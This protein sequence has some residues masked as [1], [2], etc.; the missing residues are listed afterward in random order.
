MVGRNVSTPERHPERLGQIQAFMELALQKDAPLAE[1]AALA[2]KTPSMIAGNSRLTPVEQLDIYREQFWLRHVGALDEDFK[3]IVHLL[4]DCKF[5]ELCAAYL[6]AHPPDSYTLRDLGDNL[7]AF[8]AKTAPYSEDS[9]LVDLAR[10]EWAF[11]EAYDAPDVPPLDPS[12]IASASEDDWARATIVLHPAVQRV[13][14]QHPAD[15][16]RASVR[17]D[18]TP[19]V[20]EVRTVH[21]I[22]YRNAENTLQYIDVEPMA[23]ALL[24]RLAAGES[25]AAACERVADGADI[26]AK[27]GAWFQQW[28]SY[29]WISEVR[30]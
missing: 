23:F 5:H 16:Y 1:D 2:L 30:F 26:E 21:L 7:P 29:R 10:L 12:R 25:L 8:V 11:V 6:A 22:V 3:S 19:E 14:M 20:P 9:L 4:G 18:E 24:E 15:A 28:T 27:V 17:K 13:V